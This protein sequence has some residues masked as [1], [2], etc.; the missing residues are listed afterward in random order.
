MTTTNMPVAGREKV[1]VKPFMGALSVPGPAAAVNR[2]RGTSP[3]PLGPGQGAVRVRES[4]CL[5]G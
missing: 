1:S 4:G 5:T 3:C 2:A